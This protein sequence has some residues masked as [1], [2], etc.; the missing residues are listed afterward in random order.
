MSARIAFFLSLC[1]IGVTSSC[2]HPNRVS[3]GL[4]QKLTKRGKP[5]VLVFGSVST[6]TGRLARP[7]IRFIR[8]VN[9]SAPEFMLWSLI[10]SSG[11]R[12]YAILKT[13]PELPYLD[14]FYAE[15]GSADTGFDKITYVRLHQG[16]GPQ[17]MYVGEIGMSPAQ[18]RVAQGQ[19]IV[20]NIRDDFQ[21]AAQELKRL[22]PRFEGTVAKAALLGKPVP[23]A[24]PPARVR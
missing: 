12:F 1:A 3:R 13:P 24:A 8:Q 16:D 21:N 11:D 9:R 19:A 23:M 15:V 10:V 20:V 22:Y 4:L 17:A 18:N 5:F 14:E 6:P 7:E 2:A